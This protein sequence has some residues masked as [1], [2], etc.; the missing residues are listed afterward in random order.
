M[1][2]LQEELRNKFKIKTTNTNPETGPLTTERL[3][4]GK[5]S[6][7]SI[8]AV[9]NAL[10]VPTKCPH[11]GDSVELV[12]NELVYSKPYGNWPY[13]YLCQNSEC[14]S[15]VGLHPFTM[16]P[17]GTLATRP[18]RVA[19]KKAKEAFNPLWET[20]LMTRSDAYRW[21]A[22]QLGIENYEECHIGWFDVD[23]CNKVVQ[24]CDEKMNKS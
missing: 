1:P 14:G 8:R 6:K 21:L 5:I 10:P 19:R 23:T 7:S 20:N 12:G 17:L 24:L 9:R 18:M 13:M 15:Y 3:V 11:C 2:S 16:I 22:L 4:R